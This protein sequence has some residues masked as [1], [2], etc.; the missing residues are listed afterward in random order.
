MAAKA[1]RKKKKKGMFSLLSKLIIIAVVIGCIV[2]I[3]VTQADISQMQKK[4]DSIVSRTEEVEA[5][6][7]E[8]QRTLDED[9]IN[10][11]ME[12]LAIEKMNY[13][14]PNERRYYDTSRN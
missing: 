9:D 12:K 14:Y 6:N 11:Y 7:A 13:A 1:L 8:L 10:A 3:I 5:D 2:S 4:L